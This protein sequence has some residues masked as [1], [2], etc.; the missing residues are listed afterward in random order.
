VTKRPHLYVYVDL[1]LTRAGTSPGK[2]FG[3]P[4]EILLFPSLRFEVI[5]SP[6]HCFVLFQGILI[7]AVASGH[8]ND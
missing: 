8:C 7:I 3:L 1:N 4:V 5:S 2:S 6:D